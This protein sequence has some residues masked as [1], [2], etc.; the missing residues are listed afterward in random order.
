MNKREKKKILI[1]VAGQPN[2]GKSTIFNM[3]TG[4]R[5][6]VANY[7]GVTVEKKSGTYRYE[8]ARI[9]LVDLPGTY[10]LTSYSLE[11]RIARDFILHERPALV[12]NVVDASNLKRNLYL[13]FQLLE[14]ETP[15][16]IDLNMMDVAKRR[17]L[18][19]DT[20]EL[21]R[22]IGTPVASTVGNRGKGKK[23]L[24]KATFD[25]YNK[26]ETLKPFRIN[27]GPLEPILK[28]LESKLSR[29]SEL[30]ENYPV[31]WLAVKLMEGDSE[32]QRL[33]EK[34]VED[35][36]GILAYVE[37]KGKQFASQHNE[38]PEGFIAAKRYQTADEIIK[39]ALKKKQKTR[40]TLSDTIDTV[41]CNRF[42]GPVILAAIIYA[43]FE[44]AIVQGYKVTGYT[45]PLF[46][47]FRDLVASIL[48]SSGFIQEPLIRSVTLG[49]V[50]GIIAVLNYIPIFL[51]L[52]ALIAILEDTGYMPRMAFI[53][54][55]IFR[56]FGLHGQSTLPLI[57]GGVCVGGCAIPGVMACRAIK[58]ERARMAT[59]LTVPL[60]NCMAKIPLYTLL[61]SIF[62]VQHK[63]VVMFFIATITI[64]VALAVAKALTLTVLSRKESAPF[65]LEMPPY[66]LPTVQGVLRRCL[67]RTWLFVRKVITIVIA[68]AIVVYALITLPGLTQERKT[69]YETKA[70]GTITGFY[71]QLENNPYVDL[72]AGAGLTEFMGYWNDYKK[73]RMSAKEKGNVDEAFERKNPEFFKIVKPG[74][75]QEAKRVN[76][77]F[78]KL[79]RTR[80]GLL[81]DKKEET[82]ASSYLGRFGRLIEPF[83]K[84][85]GFN[86]RINIALL[87]AFAAKE[88]SV[89]TLGTIYQSSE[90]EKASL[91]VRMKE[92]EKGFTPLHALAIILFMAMCPPCIPTL[93]M[94]KLE[95]GSLR[96]MFFAAL[97]PTL[98]GLMMAILVFSG[99]NLL[100]LSGIEAMIGFYAMAIAI[101]ALMALIK[102][103][104]TI[105]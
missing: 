29:D 33:I 80:K 104:P 66:Q 100:G 86:W 38:A 48:P 35:P 95:S 11:E 79:M 64:I 87:S 101:T 63:G 5:Q 3:L 12:V 103:K 39:Y 23:E 105:D 53:L 45:W 16:V 25:A 37:K 61:V 47:G 1:A 97:Y 8:D 21:S 94:V 89:A 68:I 102:R 24:R 19:I 40:S 14:M 72:L 7:P 49:V 58:D 10:S 93:V 74:G 34:H 18:T 96:W 41:V 28:E 76:R 51:I 69:Y 42:L 20:Q 88:N 70:A 55:R 52:F 22:R 67:E 60:M 2:A 31:R 54:D 62:F 26:R 4:A 84:L 46:A 90:E 75:D 85:A 59:I 73:A 17:G 13:T 98:L 6:H 83:T 56:R 50:D 57:L 71:N 9:D 92:K 65:I 32:A 30:S 78:K 91:E 99:G 81:R 15:V 82:T 43:L 36:T 27:Y 77:S 44:L